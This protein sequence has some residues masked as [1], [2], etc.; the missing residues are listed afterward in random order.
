MSKTFQV[1]CADPPYS[2]NDRISMSN[3]PRGALA[4]YSTMTNDDIAALPIK[5]L[6]DPDGCILALWC[7][8]SLLQ[9]GL[10]VMKAWQFDMKQTYIWVKTKKDCLKSNPTDPN[11]ILAFGMGRLT[12]ASHELCL[13]GIN[14]TCIYKRLENKSQRSVSLAENLG[15]STK[16]EHLQNSLDL[17]FPNAS[18]MELFARRSR[19]GWTCV[20]NECPDTLN[21]DVRVS[22]QKLIDG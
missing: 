18:R 19:P 13:I 1:I 12:R 20:G 3:T 10:D 2:F 11:S 22:L 6:S 21:E 5:E 7:P 4:N 15:H 16:P 9:T 14:N 8:S 17:M